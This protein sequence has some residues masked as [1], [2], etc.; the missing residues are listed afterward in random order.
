ML[1]E[2]VYFGGIEWYDT[3]KTF[4]ISATTLNHTAHH[5][6]NVSSRANVWLMVTVTF[7]SSI[8]QSQEESPNQSERIS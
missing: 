8:S 5:N 1:K 7:G 4:A 6:W 2:D 3:N